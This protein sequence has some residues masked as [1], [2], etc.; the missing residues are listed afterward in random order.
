LLS[1]L[2]N[3]NK[4]SP[5]VGPGREATLFFFF[6]RAEAR[7]DQLEDHTWALQRP[8]SILER[9]FTGATMW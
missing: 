4:Q 8:S 1:P 7:D 9:K 5:V 2:Q 6:G 3:A